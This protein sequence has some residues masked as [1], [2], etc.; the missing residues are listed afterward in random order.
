[1]ES[2]GEAPVIQERVD[3]GR[4]YGVATDRSP[5]STRM[6]VGREKTPSTR[7]HSRY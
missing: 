3:C 6:C 1:M 2:T 4:D 7:S 5:G